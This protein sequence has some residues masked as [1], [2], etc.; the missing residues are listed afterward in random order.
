M[1]LSQEPTPHKSYHFINH[2][3]FWIGILK[4]ILYMCK[5]NWFI[6]VAVYKYLPYVFWMLS[7]ALGEDPV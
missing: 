6:V 3:M 5:C 4:R 2:D 7:G 1:R